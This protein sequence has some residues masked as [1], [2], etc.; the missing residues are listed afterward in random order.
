MEP[1]LTVFKELKRK[2]C[3]CNDICKLLDSLGFSD[4]D[5]I[6]KAPSHNHSMFITL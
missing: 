4:T 6:F 1:T 2:C 3:L 5:D